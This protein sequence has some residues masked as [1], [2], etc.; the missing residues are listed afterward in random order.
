MCN[1]SSTA[2]AGAVWVAA[3]EN[4]RD[5]RRTWPFVPNMRRFAGCPF[6]LR[7]RQIQVVTESVDLFQSIRAGQ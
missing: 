1:H 7:V 2:R 5:P 6:S 3:L 4:A